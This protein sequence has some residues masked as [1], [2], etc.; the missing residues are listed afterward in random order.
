VPYH[1]DHH[2]VAPWQVAT[3]VLLAV[4]LLAA[5][6]VAMWAMTAKPD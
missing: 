4:L 2:R 1:P 6:L 3:V 5:Y